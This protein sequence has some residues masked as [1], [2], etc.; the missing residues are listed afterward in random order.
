MAM[1]PMAITNEAVAFLLTFLVATPVVLFGSRVIPDGYRLTPPGAVA[2][3]GV[4]IFTAGIVDTLFGG[5]PVIGVALSPLVW[6][7]VVKHLGRTQWLGGLLLGGAAWGV[8]V[9]AH[10]LAFNLS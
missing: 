7:L 6:A 9:F 10:Q 2:V 1:D 3:V 5:L 4:G 8:S